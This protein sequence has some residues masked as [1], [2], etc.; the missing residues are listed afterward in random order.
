MMTRQTKMRGMMISGIKASTSRWIAGMGV[1][2]GLSVLACITSEP[3]DENNTKN[4]GSQKRICNPDDPSQIIYRDD[5][6]ETRVAQTCTSNKVCATEDP[7][8]GMAFSA[9]CVAKC[10]DE[11]AKKVC[12]PNDLSAV[13]YADMC[14]TITT[15]AT[16]CSQGLTCIEGKDGADAECQCTPLTTGESLCIR[17]KQ[18]GN[19]YTPSYIVTKYSCMLTEYPPEAYEETCEFGSNCF[20]DPMYNNGQPECARSL[21]ET[22]KDSLYYNHGC[23]FPEFVRVKT[24][25]PVD[26]RCRKVGDGQVGAGVVN[27]LTGERPGNAINNCLSAATLPNRRPDFHVPIGSGPFYGAFKAGTNLFYGSGFDPAKRE[28]YTL[29]LWTNQTYNKTATL[30]ATNID[31][32]ARRVISGIYPDERS[33]DQMFGSGHLTERLQGDPQP[34]T[35]H[36]TLRV[37]PD[38]QIYTLGVGT[39]GEGTSRAAEIV[40]TNPETGARTLVW[41]SQTEARGDLSATFGQCLTHF[42]TTSGFYEHLT[43]SARALAVADDGAF[44]LSFHASRDGDG[45]IEISKDGKNCRVISKWG[46]EDFVKLP[47]NIV[48]PVA[49]D[50]GGGFTPQYGH[51]YGMMVRNGKVYGAS[52]WEDFLSFDIATGDRFNVSPSSQVGGLGKTTMFWDESRQ[53]IWAVGGPDRHIGHVIDERTGRREYIFADTKRAG[54]PLM[55]SAYGVYREIDGVLSN[56][57]NLTY[58]SFVLDPQDP[59]KAYF[60][61]A[62]GAVAVMEF[63]TFNSVI[64]SY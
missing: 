47:E 61:L 40:R 17:D 23:W 48:Y 62:A 46:G 5:C 59:D 38:G 21:K 27:P 11:R 15:K 45:I 31:T 58:G 12:D 14:G 20:S 49:P 26:C 35:G 37:G 19:P 56:A 2:M 63:S 9:R 29:A 55:K 25:L 43:I 54:T 33:G 36:N 10:G 8:T 32:G 34:L 4:C 13:Y 60:M 24:D 22:Q 57:H 18:D 51:V 41:R 1:L 3:Q 52:I 53:L 64:I 39:T 42:P 44:Y 7:E 50:L 28:M 16:S 6:G 30:L